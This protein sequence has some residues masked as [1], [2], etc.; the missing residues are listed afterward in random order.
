MIRSE[1]E[2]QFY[3]GMT[4]VRLWYAREALP[5]AAPS[6]EFVF[7]DNESE[8]PMQ[9]LETSAAP[10]SKPSGANKPV[11]PDHEAGAARIASLQAM[12]DRTSGSSEPA[13]AA[14]DLATAQEKTVADRSDLPER[15]ESPASTAVGGEELPVRLNVQVWM[16]R[17]V[18]L[19]AGLSQEASVRLQETLALNILKSLGESSPLS[20]GVIRWPVFNNLLAPGNSLPDLHSVMSHVMSRLDG[21]T[22]LA[23]G[24][25]EPGGKELPL[26]DL[27]PGVRPEVIFPHS[28]AELAAN[29]ALKR[30]LWHEIKPLAGN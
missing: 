19:I 13:P 15:P 22:V 8:L 3:L 16:G 4:G 30:E 26:M 11:R 23:V 2:R 25:G 10:V 20:L 29:P 17:H 9:S 24:V 1:T 5:G 18:A 14:A 12:M 6:P 7:A 28:L 21:Q 27:M